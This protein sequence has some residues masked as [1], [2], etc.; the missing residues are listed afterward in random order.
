MLVPPDSH[1]CKTTSSPVN[2]LFFAGSQ[3]LIMPM[4]LMTNFRKEAGAFRRSNHVS[5]HRENGGYTKSF[6]GGERQVP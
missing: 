2:N 3:I 5:N 6:R 1:Y 4:M